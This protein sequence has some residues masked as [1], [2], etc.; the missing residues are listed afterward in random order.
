MK[1]CAYCGKELTAEQR[2]N[3]YCSSE[4][5]NNAKTQKKVE[6]WVNGEF[7]GQQANG[8]LS[9]TV[10][11]YLLKKANYHCEKCGWGEI[12]PTTGKVPLEIHHEDGNYLNNKPE[13]LKVLCPNC[14]ALTPN[15]RALNKSERERSQTR[16]QY[17]IDCGVEVSYGALRC[18]ACE[19][20][21]RVTIKPVTREEL[22]KL[23]REETFVSIG[24]KFNVTDN[25]IKKWCKQY[26]LPSKK[27][28][29]NNYSDEE[30]ANI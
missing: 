2:H 14:H 25:A 16:K 29:I 13:N 11:N 3:S 7:N 6:A 18:K 17:C 26:D 27:R 24:K 9:T 1:Y 4:C 15:Y 19:S 5:A 12:N 10:R 21:H 30:W 22:K 28:D 20:K 23:I 8:S